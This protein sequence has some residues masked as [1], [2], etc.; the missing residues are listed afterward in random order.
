MVRTS[1]HPRM[2]RVVIIGAGFGGLCAAIQ[3]KRA[4]IE[5]FV[6]LER[7]DEVGGTWQANT[8]PGAQ[9]DIPSILYSFSFA[10]NPH[11]SR[12][13][14]LQEEIRDYLRRC[15]E[16]FGI[17]PHLRMQQEVRE[18]RWGENTQRWHVVTDHESWRAQA[19]IAAPGPFST[20][21]IP[22]FAGL[23]SFR[24]HVWHTAEWDH[25][26][27]PTGERI[28]VVGTG[29]SAVQLIPQ[30]QPQADSMTVFQRT[31]TWIMP[32]PDRPV[33]RRVQRIFERVPRLQ[34]VARTGFDL[35]Q[36]A[37]VPGLVH[38]P[39]LLKGAEWL[40]RAHLH[41]QVRDPKLRA[42]LT[43]SYSFGC[44]RPTFSN[45][46]YPALDASNVDVITE[47]IS[48][49]TPNG[50][51]TTEGEEYELDTI[52]LATG[53]RMVDNPVFN[54]IWGRNGYSLAQVWQG[55]PQAYLGTAVA[56]FPNLFFIL[57]PNSVTY[58][59]QVI[60]IEAQVTYALSA[61]RAMDT[62]GL[63]SIDVSTEVQDAFVD[64][65]DRGLAGSVWNTGGC[66]SYYLDDAGRNF[67][68]YPG[69]A[70]Q[71]WART[72]EIDLSEFHTTRADPNAH[73]LETTRSA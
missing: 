41:R 62:V 35:V 20:P 70:R 8:Y 53:F 4:G 11:W 52:V 47:D 69:F 14:P 51:T 38:Q 6:V 15:V 37:M 61:L 64:E 1:T 46:Y 59:S 68:F 45:S 25:G 66:R 33:P 42:K 31:P 16:H 72:R 3:L 71:F 21:A 67:V 34:R 10:P 9:C 48:T 60:T 63:S 13:Y 56:G 40:G 23:D 17:T 73:T 39:T 29:A 43:P 55:E 2:T 32:H 50:I 49:V 27:D 22:A 54:R 30:L 57:G 12:L 36:E 58:T 65:M 26:H 19:L 28:G 24:G 5:D 7:A 18:A 44:K